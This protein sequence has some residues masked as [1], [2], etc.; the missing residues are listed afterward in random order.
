[1]CGEWLLLVVLLYSPRCT[2]FLPVVVEVDVVVVVV[3]IVVGID[4][5][6]CKLW[7]ANAAHTGSPVHRRRCR[8]RLVEGG[9]K[10]LVHRR[11]TF[12]GGV[13]Y[14]FLI[15]HRSSEQ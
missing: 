6:R 3:V 4:A 12:S 1:M 15:D 2:L 9:G 13:V 7:V 10:L 11:E 5:V 14:N 8:R